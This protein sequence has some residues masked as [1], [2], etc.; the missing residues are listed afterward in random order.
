MGQGYVLQC[1]G[2]SSRCNPLV[3]SCWGYH[4]LEFVVD[5][6]NVVAVGVRYVIHNPEPV[7][8]GSTI[9]HMLEEGLRRQEVL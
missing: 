8:E 5:I 2:C 4:A 6:R 7:S 1:D 9:D 3:A